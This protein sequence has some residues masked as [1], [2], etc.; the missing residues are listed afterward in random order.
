MTFPT[1]PSRIA[2]LFPFLLLSAGPSLA[3]ENLLQNPGFENTLLPAWEKRT[4]DST[5]RKLGRVQAVGRSGGWA[6]VL[7][8]VQPD[9]TRLRQGHDRSIAVEPGSLVELAAWVKSELTDE[10]T[11]MLQLYCMD[12]N[13]QILAQPTSRRLS[14]PFDWTRLHARVFVP[15]GTAFVMAYLQIREG[16]GR[17]LFDD[18][19]LAVRRPPRPRSPAPKVAFLTD[20]ADEDPPVENLKT[21][22]ADGLVRLTPDNAADQLADCPAALVLFERD[23]VPPTALENLERFAR[24]GGRVFLDVRNFA[25]WQA[26]E[27]ARTKV[28]TQEDDSLA[29]WMTA[30]LRVVQ[31]S[32]TTAGFTPGQIIP[33]ASHPDGELL[34]LSKETATPGLE[35][36]A[37]APDGSPGLVRLPLG[38]GFVVAADVLSLREPFYAYVDAYYKYTL[39]TNTLTNLVPFGEYYP[40]KLS[41]TELVAAA[42]RI[43]ADHPAVRFQIEGPASDGYRIFSLNLG[44]PG[45][46]LYFLYAA[47][48]GIEWE[49]GY[50]LLTFARRVAE[51]HM[52][53]AVDLDKVAL[54]IVPCLNPSGYDQRRRQNAAGVDLNR[55]G[56]FRWEEFQGRDSNEDGV[57]SAGDYDFKGTSPF[58]QPES[59]TY[60]AIL[61]RAENLYCILDYHGNSS[62][63][64]NKVAI[65]PVTAH[66]DNEL[67]AFDLQQIANRRL[68]G[69]HLLHQNREERPSQYLLTRVRTGG[70]VPYL[71]NTSARDRFGLLIELTAAYPESYGTVLQTDVTC[72]LCRALFLA[73]PPPTPKP[74]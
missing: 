25:Q 48:H 69:R 52:S 72:E 47:A 12:E 31:A 60:K 13:E 58:S 36:L 19:E 46:P 41:Y 5:A 64:S 2:L 7:E 21:L 30:G 16:V 55:Q 4:P 38:K 18:V 3:A 70:G 29:A 51:G 61:D 24:Q 56:D 35:V 20:L 40:K 44:R 11:S 1:P 6:A 68:A 14:G 10:G 50:G 32:D 42:R 8:N 73:Y 71:I 65:L 67:R 57:W 63:T 59:Q 28:K 15:D 22:F 34:V 62:A 26:V 45:A 53:D 23:P 66:P 54:K 39:I 49:P 43:A 27:I 17:V 9:Y 33:R 74:P 37:D